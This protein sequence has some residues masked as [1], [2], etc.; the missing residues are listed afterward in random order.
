[1]QS[2]GFKDYDADHAIAA[3]IFGVTPDYVR[4]TRKRGFKDLTLEQVIKLKQYNLL[5]RDDSK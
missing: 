3:R 5:D 1:M 4:E 2:L